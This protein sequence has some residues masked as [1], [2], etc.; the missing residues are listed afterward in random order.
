MFLCF[1]ASFVATML[2]YVAMCICY[3]DM[4]FMAK[5]GIRADGY[6]LMVSNRWR[7]WTPETLQV[8]C[9][10]IDKEIVKISIK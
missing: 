1:S 8:R 4:N 7:P 9:R 5:A 10:D 3:S 2:L 6:H